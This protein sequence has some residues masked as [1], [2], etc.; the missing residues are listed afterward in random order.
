MAPLVFSIP[1]FTPIMISYESKW[2][3]RFIKLGHI[4]WQVQMPLFEINRINSFTFLKSFYFENFKHKQM[5]V[6]SIINLM[7]LLP[8][9]DSYQQFAKLVS[10]INLLGGAHCILK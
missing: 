10:S 2:I 4:T 8:S 6:N 1:V 5:Q 3:W 7:Y 9:C